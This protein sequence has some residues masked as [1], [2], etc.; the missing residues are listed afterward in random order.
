M[1]HPALQ[2]G[3]VQAVWSEKIGDHVYNAT[4]A[5]EWKCWVAGPPLTMQCH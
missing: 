3:G 4:P 2:E 1:A 5:I